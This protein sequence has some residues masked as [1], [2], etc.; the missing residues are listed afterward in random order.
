VSESNEHF[1]ALS[2]REEV[3]FDDIMMKSTLYR[4]Y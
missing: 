2:W 3:T 1:S 4:L